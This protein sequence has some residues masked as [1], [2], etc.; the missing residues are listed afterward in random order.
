MKEK[1]SKNQVLDA[2][3][4]IDIPDSGKNIVRDGMVSTVMIKNDNEIGFAIEIDRSAMSGEQAEKLRKE[5]EKAVSGISGVGKVTAVLTAATASLG[6]TELQTQQPPNP[7]PQ[8]KN[9]IV[10]GSGKGG[11]GKSTVAANLAVSLGK[12]GNKVGL[13]DADILGPSVTKLMGIKGKPDVKNNRM[14][15]I[16]AH[17]IKCLSIGLLIDE[18]APIVW[19][20]PMVG[21][22]LHQLLAGSDWGQ[23]DYLV[24]DLPPGT[25]D[26]Q[27]TITKHYKVS[28]AIVVTTP[29]EV[30]LMDVKKAIGMFGKVGVPVIGIVENM[31]FFEDEETGKKSFVFGKGNVERVARK[32]ALEIIGQIPIRQEI[33][34]YSDKGTPAIFSGNNKVMEAFGI[35]AEKTALFCREKK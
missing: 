32:F 18:D 29:Q 15:P 34:E 11:V 23:L 30:A 16:V 5:C 28:G 25:G 12:M 3:S 19:R 21:K 20:G 1:I 14:I 8:V 26:V 6:S 4:N 27:L 17:G 24:V 35:I 10:V 9:I 31:S 22:A 7:L 2:L 33:S 13:V